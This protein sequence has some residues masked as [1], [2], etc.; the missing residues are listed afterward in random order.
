MTVEQWA[1]A[2]AVQLARIAP[3][4]PFSERVAPMMHMALA[5]AAA[6]NYVFPLRPGDKR[7]AIKD[8]QDAATRD[9]A[10]I[11][12]FWRTV[13][14]NIG[15]ACGPS[16]LLVLDLDAGADV[17][18]PPQWSG[19]VDGRDVLTRL[20]EAAG[21]PVPSQTL[22]VRTPAGWHLYFRPPPRADLGNSTARLGWRVDTRG[23][24]GYVVAPGSRRSGDVYRI[25]RRTPVADLPDWLADALTPLPRPPRHPL[26]L[27]DYRAHAY[28][29][30]VLRS[31][32]DAVTSASTGQRH[33]TLLSA[34]GALGRLV[35][36]GELDEYEARAILH[37]AARHHIGY[38]GFTEAEAARTIDDGLAYGALRPRRIS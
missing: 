36:G 24:G 31:E 7:P 29:S 2:V 14:F 26:V 23:V 27:P 13:P 38:D 15:I 6:G 34:A 18:P 25:V 1:D 12:R 3:G 10:D 20:A 8:W 37:E 11:R 21:R 30:K 19:A 28:I 9:H 33:L 17:D 22:T 16:R 4:A 5:A 35:G 32:V